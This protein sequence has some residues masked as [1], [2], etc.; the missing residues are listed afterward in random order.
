MLH[1]DTELAVATKMQ[2]LVY[3]SSCRS[4][5][6]SLCKFLLFRLKYQATKALK[7]FQYYT[8]INQ[9]DTVIIESQLFSLSSTMEKL[10]HGKCG[11]VAC[12][13]GRTCQSEL[14]VVGW[15][16]SSSSDLIKET[17]IT[18]CTSEALHSV[19]KPPKLLGI[20]LMWSISL[21][22]CRDTGLRSPSAGSGLVV[23]G[24]W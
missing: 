13:F 19:L 1:I 14:E 12:V 5:T 4:Q 8:K 16:S 24:E 2:V 18:I 9:I 17:R 7:Y 22:D 6:Q 20:M 21:F 23:I 10:T 11:H 3:S 15:W